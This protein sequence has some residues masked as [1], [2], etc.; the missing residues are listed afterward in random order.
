MATITT[1][2]RGA[3]SRASGENEG[4]RVKH[5]L[6]PVT[7]Y[8]KGRCVSYMGTIWDDGRDAAVGKARW[9]NWGNCG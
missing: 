6:G 8:G 7:T 2:T 5:Y 9:K 1:Q 4:R 3:N